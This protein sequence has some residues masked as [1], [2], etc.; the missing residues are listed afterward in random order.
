MDIYAK[1]NE[2]NTAL[3]CAAFGGRLEIVKWLVEVGKA[4]IDVK[5]NNGKTASDVTRSK[6]I[7]GYLAH[8]KVLTIPQSG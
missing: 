7:S 2:G 6:G 5:N 4:N 3:H 1:S 8:R